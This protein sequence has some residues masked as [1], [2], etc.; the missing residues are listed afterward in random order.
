[1]EKDIKLQKVIEKM[2][3]LSTQGVQKAFLKMMFNV[4]NYKIGW[5]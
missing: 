1:M 3:L 2:M 5:Q 4:R